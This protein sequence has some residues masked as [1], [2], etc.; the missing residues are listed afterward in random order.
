MFKGKNI[1]LVSILLFMI[2]ASVG[3]FPALVTTATTHYVYLTINIIGNGNLT[4]ITPNNETVINKT[5]T[6]EVPAGYSAKLISNQSFWLGK[7]T[8]ITKI[9]EL[10]IF[11]NTVL[12]VYFNVKNITYPASEYTRVTLIDTNGNLNLTISIYN[13]TFTFT[14]FF[15][16]NKSTTFIVPIHSV[17]LIGYNQ[18]FY[19]NGKP[20]VEW[21]NH[22]YVYQYYINTTAPVVLTV[23]LATTSTV[24]TTTSTS[25]T[26]PSTTIITMPIPNTTSTLVAHNGTASLI[27]TTSH[28]LPV[29]YYAIIAVVTI[30][31]IALFIM[32][33]V[34]K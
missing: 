29:T 11:N 28:S 14:G 5:T 4:I 13:Q 17:V 34:R 8:L 9:A 15:I 33:R 31:L 22:V 30:I 25:T 7:G 21:P 20:T 12:N 1:V 6:F 10:Y 32:R 18:S 23:T 19:V 26:L 27:I 24:T 3:Y 2:L 16:T